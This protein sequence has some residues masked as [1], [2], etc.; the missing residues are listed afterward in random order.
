MRILHLV[1]HCDRG[2]NVHVP[3]DLACLQAINGHTVSYASVGGNYEGLLKQC[4]VHHEFLPQNL[5][6]PLKAARSV[7]RLISFCRRFKPDVLHA[8]M[9]SGAVQGYV[10][11]RLL[12]IPMV[13]TVHNSFDKHARLMRL[14][15]CAVAVSEAERL[16]LLRQGYRAARVHVVR[17]GTIGSPRDKWNDTELKLDIRRPCVTTVCGLERRKGVHDLI[18]A[19]R[20]CC[21]AGLHWHLYI[22]GDGPERKNLEEKAEKAGIEDR[23]HFLGFVANPKAIYSSTDIF[24]LASYADT[25]ALVISEGREAGCALVATAVGGTPEQLEFGR[26]GQLFQPGDVDGLARELI[27]LMTQPAALAAAKE[28]AKQNTDYFS[29]NRVYRDYLAV[30]ET[31]LGISPRAIGSKYVPRV[32]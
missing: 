15:D 25:C 19:F 12:G 14:G 17:N 22:V 7:V 23:V 29:L 4:G 11:S 6:N 1:N 26:A 32:Q 30:Y 8:H 21:A 27:A 16:L 31:A 13:T 10:V 2:G 18:D 20:I 5:R 9:M 3:V 28:R 24:V